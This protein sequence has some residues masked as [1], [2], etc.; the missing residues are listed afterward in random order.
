MSLKDLV[1]SSEHQGMRRGKKLSFG[2][3]TF[4][5]GSTSVAECSHSALP[6]QDCTRMLQ[7]ICMRKVETISLRP[8]V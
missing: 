7:G 1:V 2:L 3:T 5:V 8:V 4:F 6:P